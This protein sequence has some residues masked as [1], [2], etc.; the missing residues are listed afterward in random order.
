[1]CPLGPHRYQRDPEASCNI[2]AGNRQKKRGEDSVVEQHGGRKG[3]HITEQGIYQRVL[4][5]QVP[6]N[7][8][9]DISK[10]C[11][12]WFGQLH[13]MGDLVSEERDRERERK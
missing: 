1:M 6:V 12:F 3:A 11:E 5:L 2:A 8:I 10:I 13:V 4:G 7:N 9:L